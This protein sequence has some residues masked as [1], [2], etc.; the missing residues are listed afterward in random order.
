MLQ[1]KLSCVMSGDIDVSWTGTT[2]QEA[3]HEQ[4]FHI[5]HTSATSQQWPAKQRNL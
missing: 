5:Q 3:T 1:V 4:M 2:N